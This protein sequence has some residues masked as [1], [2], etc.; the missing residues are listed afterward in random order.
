MLQ[1]MSPRS[2]RMFCLGAGID[3][4]GTKDAM[5][6]AVVAARKD[7]VFIVEELPVLLFPTEV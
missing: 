3:A 2:I 4:G 5:I 1:D 7:G 6:K